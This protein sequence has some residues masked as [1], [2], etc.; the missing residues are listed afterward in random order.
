MYTISTGGLNARIVH[1]RETFNLMIR[2][3][4][5]AAILVH[6]H[7]SVEPSPSPEDITLTKKLVEV[8]QIIG[9][10]VLDH[11]IVGQGQYISL[12]EKGML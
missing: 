10:S 2:R 11:I 4:C 8:G 7:P 12:K 3:A 1:P 5:A 6:N 9:I